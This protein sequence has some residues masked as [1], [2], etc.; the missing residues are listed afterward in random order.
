MTGSASRTFTGI[1]TFTDY[2]SFITTLSGG[3][4]ATFSEA[5]EA[6][7]TTLSNGDFTTSYGSF[8][9]FTAIP[10]ITGSSS[11]ES[12]S[13]ESSSTDTSSTDTSSTAESSPTTSSA[14]ASSSDGSALL[15]G[16]VPGSATASP[17]ATASTTSAA[18]SDSNDNST[19]PASVLAGGIV[20]GVAGLAVLLLVAMVFLR[21]Y[22]RRAANMQPLTESEA[23]RSINP[24][25]ESRGPGMAQRAGLAPVLAPLLGGGVFKSKRQAEATPV[26]SGTGERGFQRVSGRK[27]P[28]AFSEGIEGVSSPLPPTMPTAFSHDRGVS[29]SSFY[30]DSAGYPNEEGPFADASESD[31]VSPRPGPARIPTVH[32]GGP[33]ASMIVPTSATTISGPDS[34]LWPLGGQDVLSP[35]DGRFTPSSPLSPPL[36]P[37]GTANRSMTPATMTSFEGSR[38]SRFTEEV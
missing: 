27:L 14:T 9:T 30:R 24:G 15:G 32:P 28:S 17:T 3:S 20:G 4:L 26:G 11:A 23:A 33:Y 21:W 1:G 5:R 37:P 35:M 10:S 36:S 13:S 34:P 16:V 29:G 31:M 38:G 19:P 7:V 8:S 18:A 6:Q 12:S 22:R 25:G 2:S